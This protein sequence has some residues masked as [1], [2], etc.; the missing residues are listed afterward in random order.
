MA[1]NCTEQNVE[2]EPKVDDNVLDLSKKVACHQIKVTCRLHAS[3][4]MISVENPWNNDA[5]MTDPFE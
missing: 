3:I 4:G 5:I 2:S 1:F